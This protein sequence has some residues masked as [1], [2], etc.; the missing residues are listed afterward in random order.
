[1]SCPIEVVSKASDSPMIQ[2]KLKR[3]DTLR[4]TINAMTNRVK[5]SFSAGLG[6]GPAAIGRFERGRNFFSA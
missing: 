6:R 4:L 5:D 1:M 2:K 3:M